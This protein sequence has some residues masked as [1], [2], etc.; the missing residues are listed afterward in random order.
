MPA[1]PQNE[2]ETVE[3]PIKESRA[4]SIYLGDED[5]LY[6][7]LGV[8]DPEVHVTDYT[9]DGIRKILLEN[10]AEIQDVVVLIKPSASSNYQNLVDILD[11]MAITGIQR[12]AIV[13]AAPEDDQLILNFEGA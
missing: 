4:L 1:K 12:Y 6:W 5:K 11:E 13:D 10:N 8:T 3:Q 9:K 7:F 2:T